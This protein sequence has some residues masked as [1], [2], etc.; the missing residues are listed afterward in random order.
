MDPTWTRHDD[1]QQ[2]H[3]TRLLS[4]YYHIAIGHTNISQ[5]QFNGR[6]TRVVFDYD[7]QW[8]SFGPNPS[9]SVLSC[10]YRSID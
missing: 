10:C 6:K 2:L 7:D 1:E 5:F 4:Y 3:V 8:P 9:D